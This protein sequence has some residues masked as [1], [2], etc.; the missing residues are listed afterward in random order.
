MFN[1]KYLLIRK[2]IDTR[3]LSWAQLE[4][5]QVQQQAQQA[6]PRPHSRLARLLTARLQLERTA[7]RMRQQQPQPTALSSFLLAQGQELQQAPT[8]ANPRPSD[9]LRCWR[10]PSRWPPS[11]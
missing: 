1:Q 5:P 2:Q 8:P 9:R 10:S 4:P 6:P 11:L 3:T 7:P